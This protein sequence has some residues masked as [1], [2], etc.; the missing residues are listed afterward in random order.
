[1]AAPEI[2]DLPPSEAIEYFEV[3]G[4]H[5]AW[6][7]RDTEAANHIRSFTVA[8]AMETD[9][10]VEI[11]TAVD[12]AIRDGE[13][14]HDFRGRLEPFLQRKG[15]WGRK[16]I[17]GRTVQLGSVRRLRTIFETN[18]RTSYSHG[19]WQRIQRIKDARPYL[20]YA[21]VRDSRTRPQ[22]RA[23]DGT[24]LPVDHPFWDTHCPP[25]GW[26]CRCTV[27]QLSAADLEEFGLEVWEGPPA[28]SLETRPWHNKRTGVT[29]QV[30]R[31]IDPGFERNFGRHVPGRDASNRLIQKIDAAPED[32]PVIGQPW[33]TPEFEA[34]LDGKAD[35][36]QAAWPI[37]VVPSH[38]LG[39]IKARSRTLRLSR[40]TADKQAGRMPG[41]PGHDDVIAADYAKAQRILTDGEVFQVAERVAVGFVE[42]DGL[43]MIAIKS[44]EDGK[45]TSLTSLHR[46]KRSD[47]RRAR[48]RGGR[49]GGRR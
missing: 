45:E 25:N 34:H 48:R 16:E 12:A 4:L 8:K 20:M 42:D 26:G 44:S 46:A 17:D 39:A 7:W 28:G 21:A 9:I 10:L 18:I 33:N 43:W 41:T 30:P 47:L 5:P 3:K 38:I 13:T 23:W 31:G 11:R 19:R 27:H 22:H 14:F 36:R 32:L 15:W 35:D 2:L 40:E 49:L 37:A 1:M 6:D 24:V 29:V